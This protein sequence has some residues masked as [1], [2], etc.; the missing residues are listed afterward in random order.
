MNSA[1]LQDIKIN[2]QKPVAFLHTSNKVA[3]KEIKESIPFAIASKTIR[4]LRV[5]LAKDV[6]GLYSENIKHF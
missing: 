3:G 1:E 6:Q 2:V 5:K 4:Y